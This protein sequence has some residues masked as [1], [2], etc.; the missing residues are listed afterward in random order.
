MGIDT[1]PVYQQ[2]IQVAIPNTGYGMTTYTGVQPRQAAEFSEELLRRASRR[3]ILQKFMQGK[4]LPGA[5][6]DQLS[7]RR[8]EHLAPNTTVLLEGVTPQPRQVTY[9][10]VGIPLYQYGDLIAFTDKT[11]MTHPD[12][13]LREF[14]DILQSQAELSLELLKW[15]ILRAGTSAFYSNGNAIAQVNTPLTTGILNKALRSLKA[16]WAKPINSMIGPSAMFNTTPVK[17]GYVIVCHSD[18]TQDI[19]ALPGF[20]PMEQYGMHTDVLDEI[21]EIGSWMDFRFIATPTY[22]P[23]VDAG[24]VYNGSGASTVSTSGTNSDVYPLIVMGQDA[25]CGVAFKGEFAV[26]PYVVMPKSS[27]ADPLAQR[28]F[29]G[30]KTMQGSSYLNDAWAV[31]LFTACTTL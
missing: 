18:L 14:Q 25:W 28:G 11:I 6:T 1:S 3:M 29:C 22:I 7:F 5:S 26:T 13:P 8:Y 15:Y 27:A 16:Q 20:I 12:N 2:G 21:Y 23:Y 31:V 9:T 17:G 10:D 4:T 30:W 24:G 19:R